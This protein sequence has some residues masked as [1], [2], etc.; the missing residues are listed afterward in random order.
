[1]GEKY[2]NI[3]LLVIRT[4]IGAMFIYHGLPKIMGGMNTWGELGKA[5]GSVGIPV[6]PHFWGFMAAFSEVFGGISLITGIL[7]RPFCGLLVIDMI[8]AS[9]MHLRGGQGLMVASHAIEVGIVFL[10]LLISGPGKYRIGKF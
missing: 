10:G 9:A 8:V 6:M 7:F 2:T 1:M 4:G 3:G 5:M